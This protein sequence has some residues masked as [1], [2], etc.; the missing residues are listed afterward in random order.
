[1][2]K[3]A[4]NKNEV[5]TIKFGYSKDRISTY[6][7]NRKQST[8][9]IKFIECGIYGD[10][11]GEADY[12]EK[13]KVIFDNKSYKFFE[14]RTFGLFESVEFVIEEK[15]LFDNLKE[16]KFEISEENK[17]IIDSLLSSELRIYKL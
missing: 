5:V 17:E 9:K 12:I 6:K 11:N 4:Q 1:M 15:S 7:F 16:F 13:Y 3:L 2:S 10:G 8:D 14:I